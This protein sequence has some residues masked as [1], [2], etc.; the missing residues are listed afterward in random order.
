MSGKIKR[1]NKSKR[2]EVIYKLNQ[3]NP[4][5]KRS[6]ARQYG[7]GEATIRKAC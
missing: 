5:S 2:F 3:P 4:R 1:L 6:M 7:M